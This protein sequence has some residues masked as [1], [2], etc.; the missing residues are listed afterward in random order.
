[1]V[2]KSITETMY[3]FTVIRFFLNVNTH[4]LAPPDLISGDNPFESYIAT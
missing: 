4:L 1:M 3:A 2:I